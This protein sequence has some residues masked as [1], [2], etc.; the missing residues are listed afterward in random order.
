VATIWNHPATARPED[1]P[2]VAARADVAGWLASLSYQQKLG[3]DDLVA[4][5]ALLDQPVLVLSGRGSWD[6]VLV[7]GQTGSVYPFG[8][9]GWVPASQLTFR[10]PSTGQMRVTVAVPVLRAGP[11]WLSYGTE[12][13]ADRG[14]A[15]EL[16][17]VLPQGRFAVPAST[18]R[19]GLLPA[20][21][22]A[23]LAEAR[24][25][26]GL[27]YM[28]A[29]TSGFGFDC[30]GLT[31]TVYKQF[32]VELP[33]DAADQAGAGRPVAASDLRP[34]DLVFFAFD[35]TVDHVGIYAGDGLMLDAPH[36]G[37]AIEVV[38]MW[39]PGLSPYY[40]GARRYI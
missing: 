24:R 16:T 17:L 32:G 20:S 39:S 27:Q 1:A 2:A 29:G 7:E 13:P 10:A 11:V 4:T 8:I 38:P 5:Q 22:G 21:G 34:G 23:V 37:A 36:T 14:P 15:D 28:W 3:L 33:R 6:R 26:L 25:F 30:S 12:V 31:Y 40:A 9:A 18:V 35:G 19:S